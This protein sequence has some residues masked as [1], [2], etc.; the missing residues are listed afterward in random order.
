[1]TVFI[2]SI[3]IGLVAG[4]IAFAVTWWL[5]TAAASGEESNT[6]QLNIPIR[7]SEQ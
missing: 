3:V 1:M 5:S 7:A 4:S 6:Q 2:V